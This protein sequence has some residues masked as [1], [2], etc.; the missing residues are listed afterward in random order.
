MTGFAMQSVTGPVIS[1]MISKDKG[2][3]GNRVDCA[4]SHVKNNVVTNLSALGVAGAT[5]G[6]GKVV[7]K[8]VGT[9]QL[10]KAADFVLKA[11]SELLPKK[12]IIKVVNESG[13]TLRKTFNPPTFS[14]KMRGILD[15]AKGLSS[16]TKAL[17]LVASAG[18]VALSYV[19]G[20]GIYKMGQIDQKYT[21]KAQTQ[22]IVK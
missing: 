8:G 10:A 20:K 4:G 7:S 16:K 9:S 11:F 12:P 14:S 3:V 21:D 1:T 5:I 13:K 2:S 22:Q 17:G 6:A 18:A 15:K 19:T